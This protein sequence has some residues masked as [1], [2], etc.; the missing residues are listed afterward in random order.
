MS[1]PACAA[2][3]REHP[4]VPV[5]SR[6]VEAAGLRLHVVEVGPADGPPVLLLHGFP[7]FWWGWRRQL[8]ALAAA[9]FR[10]V[11]PD[12]PGYNRSEKPRGLARY[13]LDPL[14]D[15]VRA[16]MDG[17]SD[18]PLP[19]VAHDWGGALGWWAAQRF[20]ERFSRLALL[21]IPHP[22]ELRRALWNNP[23]QRRRSSYMFYFQ[24]PFLP[25][26]KLRAGGYR[27]YRAIFKRSSRR[28]TFT[29]EE[30][31]VYS[32]AAAQPGALSGMLGWYR[33]VLWRPP[34]RPAHRRIEP[35]VLILWGAEDVALGAELVLP[36]VA[37]CR[38]AEVAWIENAGHWIQHEA[39]A[40]V[41]ERLLA[42]L[43]R[44]G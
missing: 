19:V 21:N 37:R 32:E 23:V 14:T 10:A 38:Q 12:L 24:L 39:A 41:N 27:G 43:A 5:R 18:R 31:D 7:E 2:F 28:G 16:L 29:P 36:S 11:V 1:D 30:L 42:F 33:A 40:E 22:A 34:K 8:P 20:P 25:E 44:S 35:P 17:L 6:F 13:G 3:V 15:V 4:G 9:G 26:R